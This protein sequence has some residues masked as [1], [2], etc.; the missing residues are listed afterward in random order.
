M[1]AN[2]VPGAPP[3]H[4]A[5]P[6]EAIA[7]ALRE[8]SHFRTKSQYDVH[9]KGPRKRTDV[10]YQLD[11]IRPY[12][13]HIFS[14]HTHCFQM[15]IMENGR[16]RDPKYYLVFIGVNNK[17]AVVYPLN[18]K[19]QTD[20][21]AKIEEF[22]NDYKPKKLTSDQEK[23]FTSKTVLQLLDD[24]KVILQTVPDSNHSTL[25]VIDRFIRT[26][27]DMNRPRDISQKQSDDEAFKYFN[28]NKMAKLVKEYN[29]T[30]HSS[31]GCT[32]KQMFD[33][34]ELEK[35]Y[36]IKC[37]KKQQKQKRI[38][39]FELKPGTH[40]R[41]IIGRNALAKNRYR[42]TNES[43]LVVGKEGLHYVLEAKDGTTI[44]KPRFQLI[45]ADPRKYK[46]ANTIPGSNKGVLKAI[47]QFHR[48]TNKYRVLFEYP[49]GST[50]VDTIPVSYVRGKYPQKMTPLEKEFFRANPNG[51]LATNLSV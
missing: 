49:D 35:K 12:M 6:S 33:D 29:N 10:Y 11:D 17:Y 24:N 13:I 9:D 22:I 42:V 34:P 37:L 5:S 7:S 14:P 47:L 16:D 40:V 50:S 8:K 27:R 31:T 30:I 48:Q 25:G 21:K 1:D 41:Y 51:R 23:S 39:D 26:L 45:V 32:P 38:K 15:N 28:Q 20:V 46:L 3:F 2:Q 43:Y 44:T 18:S 4:G 19:G 36:V